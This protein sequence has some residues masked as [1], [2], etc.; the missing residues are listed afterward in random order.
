V[1]PDSLVHANSMHQQGQAAGCSIARM[2]YIMTPTDK[3]GWKEGRGAR[4]QALCS[5]DCCWWMAQWHW[6]AF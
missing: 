4:Q 2:S 6:S 1:E 5:T 3:Q